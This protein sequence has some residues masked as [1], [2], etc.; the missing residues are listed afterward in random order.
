MYTVVLQSHKGSCGEEHDT[1]VYPGFMLFAER[2]AAIQVC[3]KR[4]VTTRVRAVALL[5]WED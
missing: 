3:L 2:E 4:I 1:D 5:G